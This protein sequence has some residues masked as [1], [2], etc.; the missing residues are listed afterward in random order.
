MAFLPPG[1]SSAVGI[2]SVPACLLE[3][4]EFLLLP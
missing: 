4:E 3:G 1:L 2:A